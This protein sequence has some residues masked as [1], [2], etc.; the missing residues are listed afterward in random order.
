[1]KNIIQTHDGKL[2]TSLSMYNF[3]FRG[4]A[5]SNV[6]N[7]PTSQQPLQFPSAGWICGM[8]RREWGLP[9]N[10]ITAAESWVRSWN[11]RNLIQ[12][13]ARWLIRV[14]RRRINAFSCR[15]SPYE[16]GR[17]ILHFDPIQSSQESFMARLNFKRI[18][19]RNKW[20]TAVVPTQWL[21][22]RSLHTRYFF[23][24]SWV[25]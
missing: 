22:G 11:L 5:A 17:T 24:T 18:A 12:A 10:Y 9:E 7:H 20:R 16:D 6:K 2:Q 13:R 19:N 1:M 8:S 21:K 23:V 3:G 15:L 14:S 4:W 25:I